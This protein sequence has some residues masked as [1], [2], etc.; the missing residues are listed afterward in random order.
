MKLSGKT[1][2]QVDSELLK[3]VSANVRAERDRRI[4]AIQWRRDRY[5]DELALGLTPTESIDPILTYIQK[6]RDVPQLQG[7]PVLFDWPEEP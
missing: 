6:L 7:F 4:E 2:A 1:Q 3:R 5:R